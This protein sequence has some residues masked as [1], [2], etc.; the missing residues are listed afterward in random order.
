MPDM[1][2]DMHYRLLKLLRL[3]WGRKRMTRAEMMKR[4]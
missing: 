1:D 3:I 2:N 4:R